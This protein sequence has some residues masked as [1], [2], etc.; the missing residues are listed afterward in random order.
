MGSFSAARRN[1]YV[2]IKKTPNNKK[3]KQ[4]QIY[5]D[6]SNDNVD[7]KDTS[8]LL[9]L[10]FKLKHITPLT[11]NQRIAFEAFNKNKNLVLYGY[12]GTG[13][14]FIALYLAFEKLLNNNNYKKI[15]IIRSAVP[16]RSIGFLPGTKQ[17]K[18]V[19]YEM[20]YINICNELFGSTDSYKNLKN[21]GIL[22]FEIT[23]YL[24]GVTLDESIIIIDE[25]QNMTWEELY[26]ILT[27]VGNNSTVIL[28]GDINQCDLIKEE[29]GFRTMKKVLEKMPSI[30]FQNF[31]IDDIVR[32]GFVKSLIVANEQ[33]KRE[34]YNS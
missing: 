3:N 4:A 5:S 16:S 24:R 2:T 30:H 14:T 27:R 26:T 10:N 20:P 29:S 13:K 1:N 28:S 8:F 21:K 7:N 18:S 23:S 22:E 15:C 31:E 9:R 19:V 33:V 12:A 6:N 34:S 25:W 11:Q 17:E 32:S